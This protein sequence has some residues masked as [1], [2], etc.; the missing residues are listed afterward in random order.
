MFLIGLRESIVIFLKGFLMG[1]ADVVP[2]VSGGTMALITGI[3]ERFI[4]ALGSINFR[5]LVRFLRGDREGAKKS[6]GAIDI[7]FLLPLVLGIGCALFVGAQVIL[8]VLETAP[9]LMYAFFFGLILASAKFISK[10]VE[11]I[12]APHFFLGVLGFSIVFYVTGLDELTNNN[13]LPIIFA[14]GALAACAMILPGISG[15]LVLFILGQYYFFL[16]AMKD[17]DMKILVTFA[18]GAVTGIL[19]FSRLLH[20]LLE[21][22]RSL[23]M[24]FLFGSMLGALRK[25]AAEIHKEL[26]YSSIG[27]VLAI[28][29]VA[30]IGF[31]LVVILERKSGDIEK[32]LGLEED[33]S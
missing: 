13:S 16:E 8:L 12:D 22:Y 33:G 25:P 26:D 10:Y 4:S 2:G 3:Y 9:G 29:V 7:S 32:R 1:S 19:L 5:F 20:W 27:S 28:V 6:W 30:T 15:S 14:A 24:V 21:H 18:A 17:L 31:L 11:R 23:T